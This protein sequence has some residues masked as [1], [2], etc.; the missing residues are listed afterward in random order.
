LDSNFANVE[1]GL[2]IILQGSNENPSIFGRI[3]LLDGYISLKE[4]SLEHANF[5]IE[6][7]LIDFINPNEINPICD[8]RCKTDVDD[9][10]IYAYFSGPADDLNL[11]FESDPPMDD[12]SLMYLLATGS[13]PGDGGEMGE[14]NLDSA[15]DL[16]I[17]KMRDAIVKRSEKA[18][19]VDQIE[20]EPIISSGDRTGGV[21]VTTSKRIDNLQVT[22]SVILG[23]TEED[24]VYLEYKLND[25][26]YL[27]GEKD[28]EGGLGAGVKIRIS[29]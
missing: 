24:R 19:P 25:M 11:R 9:I 6:E 7:G 20:V 29:F 12:Y 17:G 28:E 4:L 5:E 22:Y 18:L 13:L 1:S 3:N 16:L 2:E 8:I 26:F 10:R 23:A 21:R 27:T 15:A 14:I